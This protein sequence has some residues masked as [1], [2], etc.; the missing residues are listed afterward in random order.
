MNPTLA[1]PGWGRALV[2][3]TFAAPVELR[4]ARTLLRQWKDDDL[5]AWCTMNADPRVRRHFPGVLSQSEALAE[6]GRIRASLAQRGWGVWALELPGRLPF[7]GFC[8]LNLPGFDAPFMPAVEIGWR[9]TPE[10]WG[11]GLATEAAAAA[12]A[13]AFDVLELPQVVSYTVP[14]NDASRRVMQRLGMQHDAAD[15]FDHPRFAPDHPLCR[16]VLYRVTPVRFRASGVGDT[17]GNRRDTAARH[18]APDR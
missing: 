2:L 16:H 9:L 13:F 6:A 11:Q 7:A 14:D 18:N 4:S 10:A 8:G 3:Q 12:L 5:P 15:D 17:D 1:L